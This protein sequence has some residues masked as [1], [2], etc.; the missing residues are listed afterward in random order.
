MS[1]PE[2]SQQQKP[3]KKVS[4]WAIASFACYLA[5][6]ALFIVWLLLCELTDSFFLIE[7]S[8]QVLTV[9]RVFWMI[10]SAL[11]IVGL[12]EIAIKKGCLAGIL[13]CLIGIGSLIGILL[14]E[15]L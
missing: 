7:L 1:E 6:P 2:N 8:G 11:G 12:I 3:K 4:R 15:L 13:M 5:G 14:L 9:W 10:S